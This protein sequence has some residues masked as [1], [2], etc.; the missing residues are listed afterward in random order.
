MINNYIRI[1]NFEKEITEIQR[2]WYLQNSI[3]IT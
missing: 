3:E 1:K 2:I